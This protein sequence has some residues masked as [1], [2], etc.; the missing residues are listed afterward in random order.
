MS[1]TLTLFGSLVGREGTSRKS[2]EQLGG[3]G[4]FILI[5]EIQL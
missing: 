4:G 2:K 5:Y 3:V 1:F